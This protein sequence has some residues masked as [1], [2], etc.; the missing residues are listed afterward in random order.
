MNSVYLMTGLIIKI[1]SVHL[2][3][4]EKLSDDTAGNFK[5]NVVLLGLLSST[6]KTIELKLKN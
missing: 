6:S 3:C 5:N 1:Y 4:E 2:F